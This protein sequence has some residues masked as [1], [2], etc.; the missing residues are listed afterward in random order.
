MSDDREW[1]D[2]ADFDGAT[3][4]AARSGT[5]YHGD[6]DCRYL[7]AVPRV[8]GW[9]RSAAWHDGLHPCDECAEWPEHEQGDDG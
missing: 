2:D 8:E 1:P 6:A 9:D 4:F 3:V 7:A 5:H